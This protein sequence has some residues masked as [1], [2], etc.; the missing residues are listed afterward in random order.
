[1]NSVHHSGIRLCREVHS[2]AADTAKRAKT[3][4]RELKGISFLGIVPGPGWFR[5]TLWDHSEKWGPG[6]SQPL[7]ER[8]GQTETSSW[9]FAWSSPQS[10]TFCLC[11]KELPGRAVVNNN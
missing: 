6:V 8:V 11:L 10:G 9:K 7:P 2:T 1:M 3:R 4:A 5:I